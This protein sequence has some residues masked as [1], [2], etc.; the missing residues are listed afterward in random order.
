M[1]L[2]IGTDMVHIDRIEKLMERFTERFEKHCY[3]QAEIEGSKRFGEENKRGKA[4]YYARRFAAKEAYSKALGT[5]FRNGL[6]MKDIGV[7]NDLAGKP[8]IKPT[9][10]A[11]IMLEELAK[12]DEV[13]VHLTLSDD[14][15]LAQAIVM[16]ST[17]Y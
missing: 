11:K 10:R 2:G 7:V 14:Y 12:D 13:L 3:T 4:A 5:G 8:F 15:P 1:I 6:I 16:I 9:G 17:A